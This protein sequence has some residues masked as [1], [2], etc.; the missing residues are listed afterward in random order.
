MPRS[1]PTAVGRGAG[2]SPPNRFESVRAEEDLEQLELAEEMPDSRRVPTHFLPDET[3]RII[4]ENSSP[5]VP[6]RYS[7]N[8]YRGCEHG[9][10]YC[11]A[12]PGHETLGMNAGLDFE[13][14]IL[15]KHDAPQL[16]RKE[17]AADGWSGEPIT[18]SGVTDCYQPAERRFR[19]T[20]GCL[21]VMLEAHQPLGII[22]K[23]ALVTRD[24][25]L[26]AP[27]AAENLVHVYVSV[28]TLDA[29]LA[30]VLEPRT[31]TPHAR[32]RAIREL[33][34][35]GVPVGVMTA[36][37][38]PG[39]N[40]QEM[41]AILRAAREAGARSAGYVLLRLPF[42][43]RPIFE[44]WLTRHLP[45]KADRVR[46][47]IATTRNGRM[48]D[49]RFGSRMRG[50][51]EY[52]EQI[53][54]AFKVFRGSTRARR[55]AAAAGPDSLRAAAADERANATFLSA[56]CRLVRKRESRRASGSPRDSHFKDLRISADRGGRATGGITRAT[57]RISTVSSQMIA[58]NSARRAGRF[59]SFSQSALPCLCSKP[60]KLPTAAVPSRLLAGCGRS[61]STNLSASS[62]S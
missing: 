27:L 57:V 34:D 44:D 60:A 23:N 37:I 8:P 28:T 62:T 25:D 14:R 21:E 36:P 61:R 49:A 9:C 55:P 32:L 12:R 1:L 11:Y 40:D 7:I 15:V 39:L 10:A 51:G 6:F 31:A 56:R 33:T 3:R 29:E 53:A 42:A 54:R 50:Q 30:R 22:T 19:L 18:L 5:D 16:L 43:V 46:S 45:D 24:L 58:Y 20:R 2:V 26:L 52:A 48:N 4:A 13:T 59:S 35:A 47:L 41:P 38:I 17:L